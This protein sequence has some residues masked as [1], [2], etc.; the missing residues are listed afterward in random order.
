MAHLKKYSN[1]INLTTA[2]YPDLRD[3]ED[4]NMKRKISQLFIQFDQNKSGRLDRQ[5]LKK[6]YNFLYTQAGIPYQITDK[7][8]DAILN[9]YGQPANGGF[10]MF[11]FYYIVKSFKNF[12]KYI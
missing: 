1:Q 12:P 3:R 10:D 2:F 6:Y 7:Q 8:V 9:L 11:D 4:E 5:E